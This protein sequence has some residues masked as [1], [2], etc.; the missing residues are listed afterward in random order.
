ML[1]AQL[2]LSILQYHICKPRKSKQSTNS[3]NKL[4]TAVN[5]CYILYRICCSTLY[6]NRTLLSLSD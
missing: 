5:Y 3:L 4:T 6:G 1:I 2:Q